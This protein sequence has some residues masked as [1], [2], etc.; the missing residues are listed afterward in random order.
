MFASTSDVGEKP[1]SIGQPGN[2]WTP[3]SATVHKVCQDLCRLERVAVN[4]NARNAGVKPERAGAAHGH[5]AAARALMD[6][7]KHPA[8]D[9][10]AST[11]TRVRNQRASHVTDATA[12]NAGGANGLGERGLIPDRTRRRAPILGQSI[13]DNN[14]SFQ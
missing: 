8:S 12:R 10:A 5:V 11:A 14:K 1:G 4:Y 2:P 3:D 6:V 7:R 13:R 9:G